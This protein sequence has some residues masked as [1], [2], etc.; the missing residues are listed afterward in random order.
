MFF[1]L[2]VGILENYNPL[3]VPKSLGTPKS[4]SEDKT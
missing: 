3:L 1:D 2:C 4:G